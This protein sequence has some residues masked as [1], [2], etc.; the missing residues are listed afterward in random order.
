[1]GYVLTDGING[2][3]S[4]FLLESVYRRRMCDGITMKETADASVGHRQPYSI[5]CPSRTI[6]IH[7]SARFQVSNGD[8]G[9]TDGKMNSGNCKG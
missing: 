1:M 6:R 8:E 2:Y 3:L 4:R 7:T 5:I 9:K